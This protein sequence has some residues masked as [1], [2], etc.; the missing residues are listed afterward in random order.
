LGTLGQGAVFREI[1][2]RFLEC[3][4][5]F[6]E[7]S[8]ALLEE[9]GQVAQYVAFPGNKTIYVEGDVCSH[10]AFLLSG[11]IRVFKAGETGRE[12]T[13]YEIGRGDTCILNAS[14]IMCNRPYPAH[15]VATEP[16]EFLLLPAPAFQRLLH[17]SP[18]MQD[19]IF[20]LL[21]ERLSAVM[22]LVEEVAFGRMDERLE[23]YLRE[24]S[25]NRILQAT[26][27]AIANDLGSSREVVS[28]LLKDLERRGK[29]SLSRNRIEIKALS[30]PHRL[31][32]T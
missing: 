6:R 17:R 20:G 12:I 23:D 5:V 27:Q 13:L 3:F 8:G 32:V 25:R 7:D 4:P 2:D 10:I 1:K 30:G 22:A 26:H 28:R 16:G 31:S 11:G 18:R 21:S 15:A 9:F 14:S 24:R 29:I 19:F